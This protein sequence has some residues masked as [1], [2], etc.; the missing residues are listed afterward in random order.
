MTI[1]NN[2]L[3]TTPISVQPF[4]IVVGLANAD[5]NLL[6]ASLA[7]FEDAVLLKQITSL[8]ES[9]RDKFCALTGQQLQASAASVQTGMQ[10]WLNSD[11]SDA[12]LRVLLWVYL[13]QALA[14]PARLSVS[15]RGMALLADDVTAAAILA[16]DPPGML[17]EGK[18]WLGEHGWDTDTPDALTLADIVNPVLEELI[19]AVLQSG[20][21]VKDQ[22]ARAGILEKTREKLSQL[23]E[24]DQQQLLDS[25]GA[26][27][28][29]DAAIQKML[30]TS[31]GLTAF[32]V[33]VGVSGFAPY[34]LA[35][36]ASAFIPFI[37][38][39]GLVSLVSVVS[40]P[41]TVVAASG[42]A[43]WWFSSAAQ[44][45]VQSTVAVRV[46]SLLALLGMS[47]AS[48]DLS[49]L[50]T[51][52]DA[53]SA[54]QPSE[55]LEQ[56]VINAY[57]SEWK[58]L[59]PML[60]NHLQKPNHTTLTLMQRPLFENA[61]AQQKW[62][63]TFFP[64]QQEQENAAVLAAM[65]VGDMLYNAAAIDPLVI[66]A[67]DFSRAADLDGVFDFSVFASS[68]EEMSAA[69]FT[70]AVSNLKGYVAERMV[71][72]DLVANGHV[73]TFPE[74]SNQPGYDL[75]VDGQPFQVKFHESLDGLQNHFARYDYPVYANE[76]LADHI[77][78]E[79]ADKVFF[80]HGM[81]SDFV[82]HFTTHSLGA[83]ADM[84]HPHVPVFALAISA[85]RSFMQWQ[86]GQVSP[87]QA[88]E[89]V[90]MD[91]SVRVGL[92]VSG[93]AVGSTLGLLVFGPAGAWIFGA[94]APVLAQAQT[95]SVAAVLRD[96]IQTD[97]DVQWQA[98]CAT[99]IDVFQNCLLNGLALKREQ[100]AEKIAALDDS[101]AAIYVRWRLAE[102]DRFIDECQRRLLAIHAEQFSAPEQHISAILRW[103]AAVDLHPVHYQQQLAAVGEAVA[104]K[105]SLLNEGIEQVKTLVDD[106][107]GWF[108]TFV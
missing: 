36:Q 84:L 60:A 35:A 24:A 59:L 54:L 52:F 28:M 34:L 68:I 80:I 81:D 88:V 73:V 64:D 107:L 3:A 103:L 51:A 65:T 17:K 14:L 70:G 27:E 22:Q 7:L 71:A 46:L 8:Y 42:A 48:K 79:W 56:E 9:A 40:N 53:V 61:Q 100:L 91:G 38:G 33:A 82:E 16:V 85:A 39:P 101:P 19:G 5:R 77:P 26:K 41:I 97:A 95:S 104:Q 72:A 99:S 23:S 90:L 62:Y 30:L 67:A 43:A 105:P 29:N 13:R 50:A 6:A 12:H 44:Q 78:A 96:V 58:L 93:S 75:L 89:Q 57:V 76:D 63:E 1:I 69:A 2:T 31:G 87:L 18:R 108:K 15:A 102:D 86:A 4:D 47:H 66:Q 21:A 10:L 83:G 11:K 55:H 49:S 37:S 106:A 94:A 20:N 74:L 25:I 32:G 45:Q 98:A 92:A